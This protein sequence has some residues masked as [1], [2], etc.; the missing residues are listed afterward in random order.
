MVHRAGFGTRMGR[1]GACP[2]PCPPGCRGV[3]LAFIATGAGQ[4]AGSQRQRWWHRSML[5]SSEGAEEK[6]QSAFGQA[7]LEGG[8]LKSFRL[9]SNARRQSSG[10]AGLAVSKVIESS[11]PEGCG[12]DAE[13]V[14]KASPAPRRPVPVSCCHCRRSG[15]KLSRPGRI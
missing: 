4:A 9:A 10:C 11:L 8:V 13:L 14:L 15:G 2:L 5:A 1:P 12:F 3:S 6:A 7:P